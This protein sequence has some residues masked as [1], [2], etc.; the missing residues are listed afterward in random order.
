MNDAVELRR[1]LHDGAQAVLDG[2][3]EEARDLLLAVVSDDE[4][5]A[6]AWLWL[7]G[8][9]DDPDD[10]IV[11]LQNCLDLEPHPEIVQRAQAGLDWMA[12]NGYGT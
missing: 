12:Q 9:V 2:K 3:H 11:A 5:N 6:E 8:A 7:S 4:T 10:V 1:K